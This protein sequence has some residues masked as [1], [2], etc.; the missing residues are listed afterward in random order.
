MGTPSSITRTGKHEDFQL[1][2]SREQIAFHQAL[3]KFGYNPDINGVEETVWSQGGIYSYPTTAA[4]LYVS[5]SSGDDANGGTGANSIK[6]VGL[7]ADYNE[8]EEDITLTGQTQKIT[9]TSW[10]RVY[11]MYITLAGSGGAAAGTIYLANTGASAGVPTGT[12]YASILLGSGQTEMAVYTVPAGYTLYLDDINFTSAVSLANSYIQVRFLQRDF[13]TNVFR[14]QTRI[15]L[16]SNTYIF[17]FEYPLRIP[18]KTDLEV[19][20][21]SD[22]SNNNPLSA[23]WQGILIKNE[24]P[25]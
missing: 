19:R 20:A 24:I 2:V 9:Q 21:I 8:V 4:Q 23:T 3:Y 22:G 10:L 18:E 14:E 25:A 6:I 17:K 5:S 16:Q 7:D 13:G 12:V 1:Q 15:V 11:R